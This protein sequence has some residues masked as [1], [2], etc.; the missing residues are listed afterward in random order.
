MTETASRLAAPPTPLAPLASVASVAPAPGARR[1]RCELGYLLSGLPLGLAAFTVAVTGAALGVSTLVVWV[2]LPILAATLRAARAL[3]DRERRRVAA[4][5]GRPLPPYRPRP[6]GTGGT[7]ALRA[8]RDPQ[9]WRDLAHPV[10]AFPL[11]VVT[12]SVALTW[13]LGGIG[14]LLYATW[15]WSLPRGEDNQGLAELVFGTSSRAVDI[16][17]NTAIGVVLLA[18]AA[19]VVRALTTAQTR[20]AT[21]LLTDR[22]A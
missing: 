12:F 4:V 19:P 11:Q 15:S 8:V 9:S 10:L 1:F 20:L 7:G 2:G 13:T 17:F 14:E 21:T 6:S 5:T 22:A 3:A 18:T 16:G